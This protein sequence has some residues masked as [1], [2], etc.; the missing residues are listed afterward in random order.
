[1]SRLARSPRSYL[2]DEYAASVECDG[3]L[4]E[5]TISD[6]P[7]IEDWRQLRE[8]WAYNQADV[9]IICFSIASIETLE[10]VTENGITIRFRIDE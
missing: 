5:L 6:A 8:R 1:M 4:V 7:G 9:S 3:Q 2:Y 10:N